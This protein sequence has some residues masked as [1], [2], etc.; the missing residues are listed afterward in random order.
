MS[1]AEKPRG[2]YPLQFIHLATQICLKLFLQRGFWLPRKVLELCGTPVLTG[3]APSSF[4]E[5]LLPLWKLS[6]AV[7]MCE[8]C[9]K[10]SLGSSSP[11]QC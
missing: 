3:A 11:S 4:P 2:I 8:L 7:S 9:R 5:Q 1:V 10:R 6:G